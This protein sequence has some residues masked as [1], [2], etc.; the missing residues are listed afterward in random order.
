MDCIVILRTVIFYFGR[1][2]IF[3]LTVILYSGIL[4]II[5]LFH[6]VL[7]CVILC[8]DLVVDKTSL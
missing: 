8:G 5:I 1:L 2:Y 4:W 3:I 7:C 6:V